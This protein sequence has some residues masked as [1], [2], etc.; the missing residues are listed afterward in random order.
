MFF[1][2]IA[3]CKD[4][5]KLEEKNLC[6]TDIC[7]Q[8]YDVWKHILMTRSNMSEEYFDNHIFPYS[9]EIWTW[10][11]GENFLVY[12][13]VKIDW[14]LYTTSDHFI[15]KI[16]SP[17]P[18]P[19]LTAPRGV[20]LT[21]SIVDQLITENQFG[22]I[23]HI[24]APVEHLMYSS[25]KK[26]ISAMHDMAGN[27][28]IKFSNYYYSTVEDLITPNGHPYMKGFGTIDESENKCI[29]G[30]IDLVTGDCEINDCACYIID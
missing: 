3:G 11:D 28:K 29:S 20:Y 2:I 19:Y 23:M 26:A 27:N 7:N 9:S 10:R 5:L 18:L 25:Q 4:K 14:M 24:I 12:Y 15:I 21:D 22:Q 6:N 8:Y 16:D 13:Q 30:Q 17:D 1:I